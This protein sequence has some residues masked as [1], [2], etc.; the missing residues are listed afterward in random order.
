MS[1]FSEKGKLNGQKETLAN[2]CYLI[3]H[4]KGNLIWEFGY[5]QS[6]ADIKGGVTFYSSFHK[7]MKTKLTEQ[8]N[9]IGLTPKDIDKVAISHSHDDHLGNIGLFPDS[10]FIVNQLEHQ[11]MFSDESK[12]AKEMFEIYAVMEKADTVKFDQLHDVFG[13]GSVV[14]KSTPGHTAGSSVLLVRLEK[15]GS[16]LLTGDLYTH[17]Q[18]REL[19]TVPSFVPYKQA[20]RDSRKAFEALAKKENAR[21][22]IHHSKVDFEA[23]P[24]FPK[25][26]D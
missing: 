23:M 17:S 13:D 14:I 10:T 6:L 11:A 22:L 16:L 7:N 24:V 18:A 26:L 20:L 15:A 21:V 2:P 12:A 8:L 5:Q 9:Q 25:Y 4:P 3:K 19:Q 1:G